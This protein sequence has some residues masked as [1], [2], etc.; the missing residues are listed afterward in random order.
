[1]RPC[2][3]SSVPQFIDAIAITTAQGYVRAR[4]RLT[5]HPSAVLRI[6]T[7]RD[8]VTWHA[9]LLERELTVSRQERERIPARQRPQYA[10]M[11]RLENLQ[12]MGFG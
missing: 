9:A 5:S 10:P 3:N 6:A 1:M 12:I 2:S 7:V 8:A 11:H 4:A